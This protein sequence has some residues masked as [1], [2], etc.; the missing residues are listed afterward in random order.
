VVHHVI[1]VGNGD[2]GFLQIADGAGDVS[3]GHVVPRIIVEEDDED[4]CVMTL[5]GKDNKVV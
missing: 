2:A 3:G 5:C 4:A 1:Q